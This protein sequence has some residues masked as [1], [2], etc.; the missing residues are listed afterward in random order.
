MRFVHFSFLVHSQ[1]LLLPLLPPLLLWLLSCVLFYAFATLLKI[2]LYNHFRHPRQR[3]T[4]LW[5]TVSPNAVTSFDLG[6]WAQ[7]GQQAG[8]TASAE[9]LL[10][11]QVDIDN[12]WCTRSHTG[13]ARRL[14]TDNNGAAISAAAAAVFRLRKISLLSAS[15]CY[16][17][18]CSYYCCCCFCIWLLLFTAAAVA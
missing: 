14:I 3:L 12:L 2:V 9:M 15:Q 1:F 6:R 5:P 16:H 4:P 11:Q 7:M 18:C 8:I 13:T 17:C 10:S